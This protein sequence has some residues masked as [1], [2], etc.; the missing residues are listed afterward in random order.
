LCLR[1]VFLNH[2]KNNKRASTLRRVS[3]A[4]NTSLKSD[5]VVLLEM[6]RLETQL[7]TEEFMI[8]SSEPT[9]TSWSHVTTPDLSCGSPTRV[10]VDAVRV[11][12]LSVAL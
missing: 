11:L 6:F 5:R 2:S 4:E 8:Q 10:Q 9:Q 3:A 1:S 12:N 7:G